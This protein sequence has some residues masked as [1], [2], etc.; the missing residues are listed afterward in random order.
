MWP[1]ASRY[2][3]ARHT[4]LYLYAVTCGNAFLLPKIAASSAREGGR[5]VTSAVH[6]QALR[7]STMEQSHGE[8]SLDGHSHGEVSPGRVHEH[9]HH[10]RLVPGCCGGSCRPPAEDEA[11]MAHALAVRNAWL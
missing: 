4:M 7:V 5:A 10:E 6:Q 1:S 3:H 11:L 2:V 8:H 9:V